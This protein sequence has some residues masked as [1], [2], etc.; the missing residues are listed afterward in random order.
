M[1]YCG[2]KERD[3]FK[4]VA[5]VERQLRVENKKGLKFLKLGQ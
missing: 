2:N 3:T 1:L 4:G 5:T